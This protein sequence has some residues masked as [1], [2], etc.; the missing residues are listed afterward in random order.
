MLSGAGLAT[1]NGVVVQPAQSPGPGGMVLGLWTP[2]HGQVA[3]AGRAR[4][5]IDACTPPGGLCSLLAWLP[6]NCPGSC[7]IEITSTATRAARTVRSPLAGGLAIGGAFSPDGNRLAVFPM[8]E[9][10]QAA[11][12]ALA[13]LAAGTVRVAPAPRLPP[14]EDIAWARWLPDGKDLIVGGTIGGGDLVASATLSAQAL[15]V[16]SGHE[17]VRYGPR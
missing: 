16:A 17:A 15:V 10:G 1:A 4:A 3:R 6:V 12:V 7:A 2:D 9:A 5:V 8:I 14:G 13:D 11:R